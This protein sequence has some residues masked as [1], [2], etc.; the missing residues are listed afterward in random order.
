MDLTD[1]PVSRLCRIRGSH[2][3][4]ISGNRL[5]ALE[6]LHHDGTRDHE[7]DQLAK[8]RPFAMHGIEFLCLL[9]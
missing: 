4:A 8:K 6:N 7:F 5:L 3:L 2:D 9:A 1:R